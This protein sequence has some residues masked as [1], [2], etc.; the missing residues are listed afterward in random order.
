MGIPI[1]S[2]VTSARGRYGGTWIHRRLAI[3]LARCL[4]PEL[5]VQMKGWLDELLT[6]GIGVELGDRIRYSY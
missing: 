3:D 1:N 5:A 4:S 2:L 6:K